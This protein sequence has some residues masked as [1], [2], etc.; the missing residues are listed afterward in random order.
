[1]QPI[2]IFVL[3]R[4]EFFDFGFHINKFCQT[5]FVH[6]FFSTSF[7]FSYSGTIYTYFGYLYRHSLKN[8]IN[9]LGAWHSILVQFRV[10]YHKFPIICLCWNQKNFIQFERT[11][12]N[13]TVNCELRIE[14]SRE[15]G[16]MMFQLNR[17]ITKSAD[18]DN[19]FRNR[20]P[21]R[22]SNI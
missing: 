9:M 17:K 4:F 11:K 6:F 18:A 21:F 22:K 10:E 19:L 15:K 8:H 3:C 12:Y 2:L 7:S 20:K 14:L 13:E 5:L 1:M 16:L